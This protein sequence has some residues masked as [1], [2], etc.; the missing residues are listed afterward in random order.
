VV[1]K[2]KTPNS[3]LNEK[4]DQQQDNSWLSKPI[5]WHFPSFSVQGLSAIVVLGEMDDAPW[6][7]L[8]GYTFCILMMMAGCPS[9]DVL[10]MW[11]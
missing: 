11:K 1:C 8:A 4:K 6:W 2:I 5:S 7:K 10:I 9:D 3:L